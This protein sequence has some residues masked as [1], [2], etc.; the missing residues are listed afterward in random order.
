MDAFDGLI[1]VI[2]CADMVVSSAEAKGTSAGAISVFRAFRLLRVFKVVRKWRRLHSIIIAITKSAQG[3]LNFL[4]VLTV[5]M[6]IYALVGMEIFGGKYMFH[7][8]DPLPR[9]NFNSLFWALITVFQVLTG[10][11]WN[12]VMH[13]HMEISAF[14]SV[15]F[16]VS[17]FCIGNYILMNIFLYNL[18]DNE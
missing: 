15:L 4:I 3:L 16:F 18:F 14:W 2:S 1:V 10:E 17:L 9:N 11:N 5:I 7:G 13:D 6:V 8:L 12:D